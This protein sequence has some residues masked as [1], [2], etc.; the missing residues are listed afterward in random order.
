MAGTSVVAALSRLQPQ[1]AGGADS[2]VECF[3]LRRRAVAGYVP[4]GRLDIGGTGRALLSGSG[5]KAEESVPLGF[6]RSTFRFASKPGTAKDI[7]GLG[8]LTVATS[9]EG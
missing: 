2:A 1:R 9:Y 5:A 6:A 8:G 3:E 4:C 7:A